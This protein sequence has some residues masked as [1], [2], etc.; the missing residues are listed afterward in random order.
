M[1]CPSLETG[2]RHTFGRGSACALPGPSGLRAHHTFRCGFQAE[3]GGHQGL[4]VIGPGRIEDLFGGALFHHLALPHDDNLI[5]QGADNL[6]VVGN[7]Q[8]GKT[9]RL[10]Q[11]SQQIDHLGL[12][13]HVEG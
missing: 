8:I 9:V 1:H 10:L 6:Q 2:R 12:D 13:T 7:E 5:G 3:G 11:I 4:G